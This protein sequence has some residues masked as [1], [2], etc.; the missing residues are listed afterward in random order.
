MGKQPSLS[1]APRLPASLVETLDAEFER[2]GT[3]SS[4][5][6][7]FPIRDPVND[8]ETRAAIQPIVVE[9][10]EEGPLNVGWVVIAAEAR[11]VSQ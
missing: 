5:D 10:R 3:D 7:I 6:K 4:S 2:F 1:D 8:L 9:G 11:E